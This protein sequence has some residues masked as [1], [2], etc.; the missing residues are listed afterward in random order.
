MSN[1]EFYTPKTHESQI[2]VTSGEVLQHA[3]PVVELR[4]P[5]VP[6]YIGEAKLRLFHRLVMFLFYFLKIEIFNNSTGRYLKIF[7]VILIS[8]T[9]YIYFNYD[10]DYF[11]ENTEALFCF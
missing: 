10:I 9:I 11:F 1:D 5:F 4:A 7:F 8:S 3:T 6:T 2:K